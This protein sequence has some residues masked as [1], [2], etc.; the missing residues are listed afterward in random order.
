MDRNPT[1]SVSPCKNKYYVINLW[2]DLVN[3]YITELDVIDIK[4][5]V[6]LKQLSNLKSS[7]VRKV[8]HLKV[9]GLT[10]KTNKS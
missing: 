10:F 4:Y 9:K 2:P 6:H 7:T 5:T 3:Q 1:V 8:L